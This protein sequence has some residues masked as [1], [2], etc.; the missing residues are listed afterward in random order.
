MRRV[1]SLVLSVA[2]VG[3]AVTQAQAPSQPAFRAGTTL[4]EVSAVVT[5]DG[6][7]V[8]DLRP[9]EVV[10]LD[11]GQPQPLVAF[12]YVDLGMVEGPAQRRDFVLVVD[13]LHIDP[14]RTQPTIGAALAFVDALGVHDRLAIVLTAS[15]DS[16]PQFSTDRAAAR[17]DVRRVRGQMNPAG[18]ASG[19]M[20]HR[21]RIALDVIG[22]VAAALRSDSA[23][24][25]TLLL[26][27]EGHPAFVQEPS[28]TASRD[29]QDVFQ[30]FLEVLRRTA[31][32]NVAIYTIDPRGLRAQ[33]GAW[34]PSRNV[35]PGYA[36]QSP[37]NLG[38]TGTLTSSRFAGE[39]SGSLASLAVNTGGL[40]AYWSNDLTKM[41][42]RLMADSR[43]YYRLAYVQP[44]PPPGRKQPL[45]RSIKV[46]VTRDGVD[47]RSRQR[48]APITGG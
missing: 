34:V 28:R 47:V 23:E 25:R 33:G 19:E 30:E 7:P 16:T 44:D 18:F 9:D 27:S 20:A 14:S 3:F 2:T 36:A 41:L 32:A 13:D 29:T 6:R 26:I 24:R 8:S 5:R 39:R 21:S 31:L 37:D 11:N 38:A 45:S 1:A 43:Q 40:Q 48:Y 10:V 12:E 42:P 22:Q 15:S 35:D 4:V 17:A 46:K